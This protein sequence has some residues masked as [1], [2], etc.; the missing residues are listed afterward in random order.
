M[1]ADRIVTVRTRNHT[2]VVAAHVRDGRIV[3]TQEFREGAHVAKSAVAIAMLGRRAV[4]AFRRRNRVRLVAP[5][6]RGRALVLIASAA[7]L[8]ANE[9]VVASA[10]GQL[11]AAVAEEFRGPRVRQRGVVA[12]VL[13]ARRDRAA[14]RRR[15][16]RLRRAELP[17]LPLPDGV[18]VARKFPPKFNGMLWNTAGDLRTW[19][20]QH[21]FAN[22]SCY[23]EALF[24]ANRLELLDPVF[25]M[26]SGMFDAAA[27]AARQQ[28][29]SEGIFIPETVWFDGLGDAAGRHRRRN[30]RA[31]PAAQALGA[32][33]RALHGVRADQA[34]ALEPLELVRRRQLDRRQVGAHRARLRPVRPGHAH[35][36]HDRQGRVSLLAALRVHAG[37]GVAAR[38]RLSD[39]ER[40]GGVLPHVS[41][42]VERTTTAST[43]STTSTATRA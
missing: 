7:T 34:A 1:I 24:A 14:Q 19:G 40:R 36:R 4:R 42:R 11:D 13:G 39:A 33:H 37:R 25:S 9:D 30:A 26:Y 2:A 28:W 3:L 10:L 18:D 22:L 41:E 15:R 35:P 38:A 12:R 5:A 21:W 27:T 6:A 20:A 17:L 8:D 23:Y 31:L 32:A 43:T 29:G 16:G